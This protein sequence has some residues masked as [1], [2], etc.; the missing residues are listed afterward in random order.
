MSSVAKYAGALAAL[1]LV[2]ISSGH[3]DNDAKANTE[4]ATTVSPVAEIG[5]PAPVFSLPDTD[6]KTHTLKQY[7]DAGKTVVLY[8]FN[9][10]CPVVIRH[11]EVNHTFGN[12]YAAYDKRNVAFIAINSTNP[13]HPQFGGDVERKSK[14]SI[15][16]PILLDP[17]GA[18][19]KMYGAKTT[20]HVYI[21]TPD[22]VLRYAGAVDDDPQNQKDA[23]GK[24]S[25]VSQALDDIFAGK[26]VTV[27]ETKPYGCGVKYAQ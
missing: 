11:F 21:I 4:P 18:V 23:K 14:W 12:L 1:T 3:A 19:G 6:G 7:L 5:K 10:N 13:D 2:A 17:T 9:A 24:V 20:P 8:W 26:P 15:Q 22:G 16:H 25:Y 27:A